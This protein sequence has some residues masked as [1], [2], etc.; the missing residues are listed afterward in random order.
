MRLITTSY[1]GQEIGLPKI[2]RYI[3]AQ[4]DDEGVIVYQA[5]RPE[6]G[7]FAATNG[8]FGGERFSLTRMSWI[9]PN[10]LWMMYRSGW[11]QKEGQ[12]VVLA[13]KIKRAAFDTI[14]ANAVRSSY[15]SDLYPT[16][17]DW[18]R[19]VSNSNVRLQWDPDHSPTGG[20]LERK[21][22][23]L[24]LRGEMLESY[25]REWIISIEDISEFVYEQYQNL[26]DFDKLI[27]PSET[28][29]PVTD[30]KVAAQLQISGDAIDLED[31]LV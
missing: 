28:I 18:K 8:Y 15:N 17:K 12:E 21:A 16:E 23:Q 26:A 4:F 25:A 27:V 5:Y 11:G 20:K 9:K 19:A 31:T 3:L 29:Y 13:V 7:H 14:L 6:I 2:G 1:T 30:A 22:I 10:F 24:G